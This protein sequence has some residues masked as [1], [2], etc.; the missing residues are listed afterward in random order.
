VLHDELVGT[1]AADFPDSLKDLHRRLG[2]SDE[3]I[4]VGLDLSGSYRASWAAALVVRRPES[5]GRYVAWDRLVEQHGGQLPVRRVTI[6]SQSLGAEVAPAL[7][8]FSELKRWS[9]RLTLAP[10][11]DVPITVLV[12]DA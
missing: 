7:G 8:I 12:D 11:R 3:W 2:L 9:V 1:A 5:S 10:L 6:P 4:L